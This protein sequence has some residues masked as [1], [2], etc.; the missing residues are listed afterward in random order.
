MADVSELAE[1]ID[2]ARSE[3][4]TE[5]VF[6]GLEITG[7]RRCGGGNRYWGSSSN[8]IECYNLESAGMQ[9][10]ITMLFSALHCTSLETVAVLI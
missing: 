1:T 10:N 6:Q 8:Y 5:D 4:I 9:C 7:V 2:T 3:D